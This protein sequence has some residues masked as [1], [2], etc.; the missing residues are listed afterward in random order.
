EQMIDE[1]G[2]PHTAHTCNMV[3]F[4]VINA[5]KNTY[6]RNKGTLADIAPTILQWLNLPIPDVMSG[7]SLQQL[8]DA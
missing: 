1:K 8:Y 2:Q 4:L 7:H 6:F 3:P 5:E